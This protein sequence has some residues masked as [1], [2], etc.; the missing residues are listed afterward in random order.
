M[1]GR[2]AIGMDIGGTS[3]RAALVAEDGTVVRKVRGPSTDRALAEIARAVD[4]LADGAALPTGIAV[5]GLVMDGRVESS[6]NLAWIEGMTA[7][8]ILPRGASVILNDAQAA[9]SAELAYGAGR[10]A[11]DFVLVTLGTGIGCAVVHGGRLLQIPAELGHVSIQA[12]GP[13]CT[14]GNYGCLE[15]YASGSAIV[16]A[17]TDGLAS[18]RQSTLRTCCEGS[19]W[20]VTPEDVNLAAYD[21]DAFA[22]DVLRFAGRALG[23]GLATVVDLFGPEVIV[24][25]GGLTG[26]WDFYVE[27]AVREAQKRSLKPLGAG[28]AFTRSALGPDDAGVV[29]A[30]AAALKADGRG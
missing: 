21:G 5:A 16:R 22:R 25:T 12:D 11:R 28:L 23:A 4:E 17:V 30:A 9:A 6:A 14:C 26:A 24:F 20:R 19:L 1:S 15:L 18:D 27:E 3:W 13:R 29:G 2:T 10:Q 8:E 7:R